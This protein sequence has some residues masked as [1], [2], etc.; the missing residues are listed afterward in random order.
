MLYLWYSW[1]LKKWQKLCEVSAWRQYIGFSCWEILDH[2]LIGEK[3][4]KAAPEY[5]K[6]DLFW[7]IWTLNIAVTELAN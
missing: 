2:F 1:I 4:N 6:D 7:L 3:S 5:E